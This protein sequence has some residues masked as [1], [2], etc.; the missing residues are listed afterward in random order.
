MLEEITERERQH[1][2]SLETKVE[3]VRELKRHK[4]EEIERFRKIKD[5]VPSS[6]L[7]PLLPAGSPCAIAI[8]PASLPSARP[9]TVAPR[10]FALLFWRSGLPVR[11]LPTFLN[12]TH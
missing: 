3:K 7:A 4:A 2:R 5:E 6:L 8:H 9:C 12:F 11:D 10:A 1:R